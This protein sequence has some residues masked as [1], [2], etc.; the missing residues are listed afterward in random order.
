MKLNS[1]QKANIIVTSCFLFIF[2]VFVIS[3]TGRFS[4]V[5]HVDAIPQNCYSETLTVITDEDYNPYSFYDE[6][7]NFSGHDVELITLVA[8]ELHMNLELKFMNW[9]KAIEEMRQGNA[10]VLMTC[11]YSDSFPG[12]ETLLKT[13]PTSSDEFIIYSKKKISS[14]DEIY[15]KRIGIMKNGNVMAEVNKMNIKKFCIEF[16]DNRRAMQALVDEDVDFVLM[17]QTEGT[18]LL[19]EFKNHVIHGY[20]SIGRSDMCFCVNNEHPEM[21]EKINDALEK[22]KITGESDN[23]RNKWLTTFVR[24]YSIMEIAANNSWA[25]FIFTMFILATA[26]AFFMTHAQKKQVEAEWTRNS[27]IMEWLTQDF[28]CVN[29]IKITDDK[30]LDPVVNYRVSERLK[31]AIPGWESEKYIS[32]KLDLLA[33]HLVYAPDREKFN[34]DVKRAK[35]IKSF[36]ESD[37]YFLNTRLFIDGEPYHYQMKFSP[38][39]KGHKLTGMVA[40][41]HSVDKETKKEMAMQEQLQSALTKAEI[42]NKAKS[43]FLFNMSHDIRTPLNAITG[44]TSMAIKHIDDKERALDCLEKMQESG[45]LLLSLINSVLDVSRIESGKAVVEEQEGDVFFS[46]GNIETTMNELAKTKDIALSFKFGNIKNRYV[47]CDF[48]RCNRIFVNIISNAIKYTKEGGTVKVFCEQIADENEG[49]AVYRYTFTDNGIGMSEEFQKHVF[50]QF[51]R[52][53][54]VTISGIQGIG[55]GMAVVKSFVDLMNGKI[56]CKSKLGEGTTFTVDLPFKVQKE[57][58]YTDVVTGEILSSGQFRSYSIK[59]FKGKKVLL[60]E[61]NEFNR[62]IAL[63]ILSEKDLIVEIAVNGIDAVNHIKEKGPDYYAF[64]LMDIQMPEMN[65]YEATTEIRKLYPDSKIPIIALSANAFAEDK[66]ASL[67]AGMDGHVAK[68]INTDELFKILS[69][70]V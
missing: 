70:F 21:L 11:D 69:R 18:V 48:G 24:P 12:V 55:L 51:S 37:V 20:I 56:E 14:S 58:K 68:P 28:I 41:L 29:Y 54:N 30:E 44:F 45:N 25:V 6:D 2:A 60:T 46:F 9:H 61:D 15:G 38:V 19:R 22:I 52:E 49:Y 40:G 5:P 64:I 34:E 16:E 39:Y 63:D 1:I 23:L 42:A 59:N 67:A 66:A 43:D 7:Y 36:A 31:Q 27:E 65:G 3:Q 26:T 50:D 47:L 53:R 4:K 8:N 62:E 13:L 10:D 32:H 33:E 17:R 35:I 57:E